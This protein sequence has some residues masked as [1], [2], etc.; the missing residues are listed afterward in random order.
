ML[1]NL[2]M[3]KRAEEAK[4]RGKIP[5]LRRQAIQITELSL[6]DSTLLQEEQDRMRNNK[7]EA[8]R[9]LEVR[10]LKELTA[11]IDE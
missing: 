8:I 1:H 10:R 9:K 6:I 11:Q 2:R 7:L 3:E 4:E 5:A